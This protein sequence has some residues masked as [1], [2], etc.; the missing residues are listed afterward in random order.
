MRG[1]FNLA[2]P[3]N[4]KAFNMVHPLERLKTAKKGQLSIKVATG[5]YR[6]MAQMAK[7]GYWGII[8]TWSTPSDG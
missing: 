5:G 3:H 1:Y 7:N 4:G 6:K 8:L 2:L